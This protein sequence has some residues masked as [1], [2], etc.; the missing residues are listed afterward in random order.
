MLIMYICFFLHKLN[1]M[2]INVKKYV[3]CIIQ[4]MVRSIKLLPQKIYGC[5]NG[6]LQRSEKNSFVLFCIYL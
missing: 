5:L 6:L 2:Q 4:I 1:K 3:F